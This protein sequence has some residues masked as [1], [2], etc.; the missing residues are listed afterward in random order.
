MLK[1][2][3]FK[4][5]LITGG[6]PITSIFAS[7]CLVAFCVSGWVNMRFTDDP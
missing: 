5:G 7:L 1:N 4:L 2:L 6:N 3:S